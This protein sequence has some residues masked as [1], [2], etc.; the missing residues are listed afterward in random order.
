MKITQRWFCADV[1]T[2]GGG[3]LIWCWD[4]LDGPFTMVGSVPNWWATRLIVTLHNLI[5]APVI[6]PREA[7][8]RL[9]NRNHT[10]ENGPC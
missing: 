9:R 5:F 2:Y 4:G 8:Y 3:Y 6:L 10:V 7:L 1:V